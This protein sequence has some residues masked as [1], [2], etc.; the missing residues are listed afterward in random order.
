MD[1]RLTPEA[2]TVECAAARCVRLYK[3][4]AIPR[5]ARR[6]REILVWAVS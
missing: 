1:G 6:V 3:W 2:G 5:P 4:P